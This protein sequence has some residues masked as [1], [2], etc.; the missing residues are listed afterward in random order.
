[1]AELVFDEILGSQTK[2]RHRESKADYEFN[3][4]LDG[5]PYRQANQALSFEVLTPLGDDFKSC[6]ALSVFCA[7]LKGM[8]EPSFRLAEGDRL[9]I[10][11]ALYQQIEKYIV[12]PK[13]DQATPSLKRILA[14]RKDENRERRQR[15]VYQLTALMTQG[16]FFALGQ[17]IQ[18]KAS[19]ADKVLDDLLNY[20]VTNTYSKL[21]YIKVR[22]VDPIAEIKAILTTDDVTAAGLGLDGEEGNVLA[23]GNTRLFTTCCQ[24]YPRPSI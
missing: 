14:D 17:P 10:E 3:R 16:D 2:I 21:Q 8:D 13:A 22:Q 23:I 7:A 19:N 24:Q 1:M 20:L 12:S 4:L 5:A 15:L 18:I 11:L 6:K 9:D